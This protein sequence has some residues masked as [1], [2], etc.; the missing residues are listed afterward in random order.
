MIESIVVGTDGSETASKAVRAAAEIASRA[1][2][3]VHVVSAF[4]P[5]SGVKVA[6]GGSDPEAS[7]WA[8][9]PTVGVDSLLEQAAGL[10]R[11]RGVEVSCYARRGD[12]A[13]AILE[14]AEEQGADMIVVGNKGMQGTRRY[15]LGS[16]PDKI[17]HHAPCS[18]L[19]IRTT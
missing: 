9:G 5:I 3:R 17:S 14:V 10:V 19:I 7:D 12:P 1:G 16:V 4:Q 18:L 6:G 8:V 15:L 2:A 11:A 13:E